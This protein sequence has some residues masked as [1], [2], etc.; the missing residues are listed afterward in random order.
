MQNSNEQFAPREA[1]AIDEKYSGKS[2]RNDNHTLFYQQIY[3]YFSPIFN[4]PS[5][6]VLT[7][8]S[9]ASFDYFQCL[10]KF[11]YVADNINSKDI[12]AYLR[13]GFYLH[14][15]AIRSLLKIIPHENSF[16]HDFEIIKDKYFETILKEK[17]LRVD[18]FLFTEDKFQELAKGKSIFCLG[19][20]NALCCI[21][22]DFSQLQN[23]SSSIIS[24]HVGFQIFDDIDDFAD[25]LKNRQFS[26]A[27][28]LV[29]EYIKKHSLNVLP[30]DILT[31]YKLLFISGIAEQILQKAVLYFQKSYDCIC[32]LPLTEYKSFIQLNI[33]KAKRLI[34]E[35]H[36]YTNKTIARS[37]LCNERKLHTTTSPDDVC[38]ITQSVID[39]C[40]F[41]SSQAKDNLWTDF[42][43]SAGESTLW[44]TSYISFMLCEAKID[45]PNI[46]NIYQE[47]QKKILSL[48]SFNENMIQDGDSTNF[49]IGFSLLQSNKID[50]KTF[51]GWYTYQMGDGGWT[52]YNNVENLKNR[53]E[54]PD[55]VDVSGWIQSH[56][57]VSAAAALMLSYREHSLDDRLDATIKYLL[58]SQTI[59]GAW[60]SYWWTSD[61]YATS[62]SLQVLA[63]INR[64]EYYHQICSGCQWLRGQQQNDGSWD[65]MKS[66]Q[67]SVFYTALAIKALMICDFDMHE[68]EIAKGIEWLLQQEMSDGSWQSQRILRI[69][70]T[71]V[72]NPEVVKEWRRSSFGV[73]TLVDDHRRVF[74]V[75]T[76]LNCFQTY[77]NK[78]E[79]NS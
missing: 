10:L 35:I 29:N 3:Y 74:T 11:D 40:L 36:D 60:K 21:S 44:V 75:A 56:V 55:N 45:F 1:Q 62:F 15:R 71:N 24:L 49:Y 67:S 59:E 43:T 73:N 39:G 26:Y 27:I 23:L 46:Q 41:L 42:L 19:A 64:S 33:S 79:C 12:P 25:D 37:N 6:D 9:V 63:R 52:T 14:E 76:V 17:E 69:P 38:A 68:K 20:V 66:H 50:K 72:V 18:E 58:A 57:C 2:T 48:G 70:A 16:W 8:L 53:L 54:L 32:E 77:L 47:L 61:V 78:N 4:I 34:K 31:K 7:T 28:F 30:A 13:E 22:G 51:E 5:Q 65:D